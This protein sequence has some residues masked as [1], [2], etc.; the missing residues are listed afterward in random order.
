MSANRRKGAG[1]NDP[2]AA[3]VVGVYVFQLW[4]STL[5]MKPYHQGLLEWVMRR[6]IYDGSGQ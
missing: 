6:G 5:W 4:V 1:I 3:I 2:H